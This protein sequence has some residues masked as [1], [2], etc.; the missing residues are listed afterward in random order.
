M[1]VKIINRSRHQLPSYATELSAGMDLRANLDQPIELQPLQRALVPTGLFMAL[2]E[3]Y[4]PDAHIAVI[5]V[6]TSAVPDYRFD[7]FGGYIDISGKADKTELPTVVA[8]S[9]ALTTADTSYQFTGLSATGIYDI[10]AQVAD[11]E[12][13][14]VIEKTVANGTTLTV[15]CTAPTA[16]QA[17]GSACKIK[18]VKINA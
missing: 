6:G 7:D 16:A 11:G 10:Y 14:L 18:L 13:N 5:N 9:S 17:A 3:G 12:D 1:K 4:D 8:T 15:Y 2:P